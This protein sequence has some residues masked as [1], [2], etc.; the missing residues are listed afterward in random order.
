M[1]FQNVDHLEVVKYIKDHMNGVWLDLEL[2][3]I[4]RMQ[5]AKPKI[6]TIFNQGFYDGAIDMY[7]LK[8]DRALLVDTE[9]KMYDQMTD[10]VEERLRQRRKIAHTCNLI[11]D[12]FP[13]IRALYFNE[14]HPR[15]VLHKHIGVDNANH[16]RI[17]FCV[18]PGEDCWFFCNDD[19]LKYEKGLVFSFEDGKD[20]HWVENRG[21]K[22]RTVL[23]ADCWS[24]IE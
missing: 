5:S 1:A 15:S 3:R 18:E 21:D 14:M 12:M 8:L 20:L 11:L 6:T 9:L 24:D 16:L 7:G 10:Y 4:S 19:K 22:I 17:Q 13:K 2:L 23:I